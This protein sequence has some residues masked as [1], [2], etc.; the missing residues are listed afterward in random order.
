MT[1]LSVLHLNSMLTGGGTDDRSVRIAHALSK[2]GHKIWLAGPAGRE[3]SEIAQELGV[4]FHALPVGPLKL[5]LILNTARFIRLQKI[6]IIHARHGR[7]YWPAIFAARLSGM[8]PKIVLSRHLAK[9]PGSWASRRHLLGQCDAL[10]AVSHYVAKVLREGDSDPESDN[11]ERHYRPPMLGDHSKI[12]VVYGGFDMKRFKP[13]GA[14][15]QRQA[16]GLEDSHYAF[17]VVGGYA[18]PRGKGQPEF[19]RAAVTIRERVPEARFLIIGRGNMKEMLETQIEKLGLRGVAWL[20]PYCNDMAA[21]MNALDCLVL[22]QVGTEAIPGVVCEAH[23]CGKPVIASN[24]DGIPEAF[25]VAGYGQL[26]KRGSIQ[27]LAE[28]MASWAQKPRLGMDERW[29]LHRLVAERFSLERAARELA[30]LYEELTA[31]N[32]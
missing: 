4:S 22:P 24:L 19:L 13:M 29:K 6:Q 30:Q 11:P 1:P 8:R 18:L 21:G 10:V 9:S 28:A 32:A 3:F 20:T 27:E 7:D 17:G 2:L 16:W 5:P 15:V 12:H 23:A 25:S 14:T 31:K 26:V